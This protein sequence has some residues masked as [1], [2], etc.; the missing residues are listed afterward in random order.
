MEVRDHELTFHMTDRDILSRGTIREV[1]EELRGEGFFHCNKGYLINLS[2]VDG[3][4]GQDV[5]IGE[6]RIPLGR[7]RKK[8]FMEALNIHME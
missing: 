2:H 5:I 8:S 3:V 4:I 6:T 1:E 7:T